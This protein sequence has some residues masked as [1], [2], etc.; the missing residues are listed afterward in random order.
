MKNNI[1][2]L[3]LFFYSISI[4]S[5]TVTTFAGG[6]SEGLHG[7]VNGTGSAAR[8]SYPRSIAVDALGNFFIADS[9]NNS[10]R[11]ITPSAVVTTLGGMTYNNPYGI[12]VDASGNVYVADT[13]NNKIL[14][15]NAGSSTS[16]SFAGSGV[17]GNTDGIGVAAEFNTPMGIAVDV[18][19]N[20]YVADTYNHRIRKID[21][22]GLVTTIAGSSQGN[23][24]GS[25]T[26]AQFNM[27]CGVALDT[28][29]NIFIADRNNN[30][31]K[32]IDINGMVSNYIGN[33]SPGEIDGVGSIVQF[34]NPIGLAIDTQNNIYVVSNGRDC[35][36]KVT[37]SG[38]VTT[39][40]G[41]DETWGSC[42]NGVGTNAQFLHPNDLVVAPSGDIYVADTGSHTIRKITNL[43]STND[44]KLEDKINLSPN[45][46]S[47]KITITMD[48]F[49]TATTTILD[50]NGR[51][52][53]NDL[54][55]EN[56]T[57]IVISN[58]LK[59][60][61]LMQITTDKGTVSKKIVKE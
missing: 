59:G 45:P 14:K 54:I 6:C 60:I 3:V 7:L 25:V 43:L 5:Q 30:Q 38:V 32:K 49:T 42:I 8:F 16:H 37:T 10:I 56:N 51:V 36:R 22:N 23:S 55:S 48:N 39:I 19:G 2:L 24:N 31:I 26:N 27:P 4:S 12:A 9:G 61:Y 35:I 1:Q 53:Q 28:G 20:V 21:T 50:M 17:V 29:G 47:D 11:K 41:Y 18:N 44:Y 52:L 40:A 57:S 33:G 46:A 13:M 34:S 58:L 15:V